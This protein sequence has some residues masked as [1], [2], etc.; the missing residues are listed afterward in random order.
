MER[1]VEVKI[2]TRGDRQSSLIAR[3]RIATLASPNR[4]SVAVMRFMPIPFALDNQQTVPTVVTV[5]AG[6]GRSQAGSEEPTRQPP[7]PSPRC[8][9]SP[10]RAVPPIAR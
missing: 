4:A 5:P 2:L 10:H 8:G 6:L 9:P 3:R 7:G 1:R